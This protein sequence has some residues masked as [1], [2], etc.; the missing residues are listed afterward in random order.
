MQRAGLG[1]LLLAAALAGCGDDGD[2]ARPTP[3]ASAATATPTAVPPTAT[4]PLAPATVPRA[5]PADTPTAT[6][7]ASV[8]PTLSIIETPTITLTPTPSPT[9]I[10]PQLVTFAVARADDLAQVPDGVDAAGRP[11]FLRSQGQGMTLVVEARRGSNRLNDVAYDPSGSAPGVEI[12]VSRPLGDGS[13]AVC[14]YDPP[15]IGG[16]PAVD[17]PAFRDD[18]MVRD[19]VADL[20]CRFND[21]TGAPRGR[22]ASAA[23]TRDAGALY[24]F[25]DPATELQYCLPIAKAWAFPVGDTIVAARVRDLAGG[26][27]AAREIVI[28]VA[29]DVPFECENGL[30][31]RAFTVQTPASR[32]VV[33]GQGVVSLDAWYVEPL[34]ICAGPDLGGGQHALTLRETAHFGIPLTDGTIL[35]TTIRARGSDGVLDCANSTA[36]DVRAESD[37]ETGRV[38]VDTGLGVPAGTGNAS[39][40]APVGFQILPSGA[41]P[42]DCAGVSP[43]VEAGGALT[44]ATA[45]AEVVDALGEPVASL[46]RRGEPFSCAFWRDGGTPTLILPIPAANTSAG[47]LAAA[48]VLAD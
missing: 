33:G 23:C 14:D 11:I 44:T 13:P 39:L 24:G 3:T 6:R 32:L 19:A 9:P 18:Q 1:A 36:Q 48:L 20:G 27:S 10:P 34:R 43:A 42:S 38:T 5:T 22:T 29:G 26:V 16:V 4:V 37:A 31:E 2:S 45:V 28:R 7:T 40:R 47:D 21:G 8:T 12:V 35:C 30:G 46:A 41:A 15:L 17:P 25:L